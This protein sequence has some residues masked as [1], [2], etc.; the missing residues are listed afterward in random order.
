MNQ[1]MNES[2]REMQNSLRCCT[3]VSALMGSEIERA[4]KTHWLEAVTARLWE[5]TDM[6]TGRPRCAEKD[7]ESRAP[8]CTAV[9]ALITLMG[10]Q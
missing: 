5:A 6:H 3:A 1:R 4:T 9:S 7:A 8:C 10:G 2:I